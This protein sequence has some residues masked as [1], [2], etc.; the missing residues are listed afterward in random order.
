MRYVTTIFA[1]LSGFLSPDYRMAVQ[2]AR[3]CIQR[4]RQRLLQN[5][6]DLDKVE[7]NL[8]FFSSDHFLEKRRNVC[9]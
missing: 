1:S 6:N 9:F 5:G 2:V 3:N 4:K 7:V 8:F